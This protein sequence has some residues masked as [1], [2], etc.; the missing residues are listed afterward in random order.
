MPIYFY[1]ISIFSLL[2]AITILMSFAW[3][4][5]IASTTIP[6]LIFL[7]I[8]VTCLLD[9]VF[10]LCSKILFQS[11]MGANV[12]R[13]FQHHGQSQRQQLSLIIYPSKFLCTYHNHNDHEQHKEVHDKCLQKKQIHKK[14][15]HEQ[16]NL[17]I[18]SCMN[19]LI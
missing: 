12:M 5:C 18:M 15:E 6:Q 14:S 2:S 3:R 13:N 16:S 9:I 7:F 8:L 1:G 10:I 17:L 11:P 19:I 4:I